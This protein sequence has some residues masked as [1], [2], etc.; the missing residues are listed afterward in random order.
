VVH[1]YLA[2]VAP[3]SRPTVVLWQAPHSFRE[4]LTL[5]AHRF[6]VPV[7]MDAL[8]ATLTQLQQRFQHEAQQGS[9]VTLILD[10]AQDLPLETLAQ[11]PLL[12][13]QPS[14]QTPVLQLVLVGQPALR[15]HLRRWRLRR[16]VQ[17]IDLRVRLA[18]LTAAESRAYIRQ[19]VAKVALPGGPL[20]TPG[21]LQALVRHARGIPRDLNQL[22]TTVLQA[23]CWAQ[24]QPIT[25]TLV[26]QVLAAARGAARGPWRRLGFAAAAGLVL[27]AGLVGGALF[28]TGPQDS[29]HRPAVRAHSWMETLRPTSEP[30]LVAPLLQQ[31]E[32]A[33]QAPAEPPPS[34]AVGHDP[35]EDHVYR[36][37][38]EALE[39][40]PLETPLATLNPP[41]PAVPP[42]A[43][44]LPPRA[45]PPPPVSPRSTAFKPCDE[46]KA[47]IQAKLDAKR[48]TGYV[49]TIIANGD[50]QGHHIVGSCEGGTKKIAFHRSR[51][52]P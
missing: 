44:P 24:Q 39:P 28:S 1:A 25:A 49:L 33:P 34:N 41:A 23:G 22:C 30:L 51:N 38:Q 47:E 9:L 6:A 46:L 40:Q 37:P 42:P 20:F 19:R 18:P 15:R 36:G 32:P 11:L 5:L 21:A 31:P 16:M 52:A 4:L 26:Q 29:R 35:D 50:V 8:G 7:Q 48:G 3:P 14:T 13:F 2:R 17:H 45:T 43:D 10:E 12:V 27:V